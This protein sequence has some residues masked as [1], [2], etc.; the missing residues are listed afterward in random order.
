M[1]A[2][3]LAGPLGQ[4]RRGE[5]GGLLVGLAVLVGAVLIGV[6]LLKALRRMAVGKD[7]GSS[8]DLSVEQLRQMRDRGLLSPEEFDRARRVV[9]GLPPRRSDGQ[10]GDADRGRQGADMQAD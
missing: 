7:G 10:D 3:W 9:L 6:V 5:T 4:A 1:A 8:R 2:T